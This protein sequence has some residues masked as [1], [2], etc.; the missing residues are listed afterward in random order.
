MYL[1]MD[2]VNV[3]GR[4]ASKKAQGGDPTKTKQRTHDGDGVSYQTE[5]RNTLVSAQWGPPN[6]ESA[7]QDA[8]P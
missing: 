7:L 2:D 4:F 5:E 6:H 1:A 8:N 3:A